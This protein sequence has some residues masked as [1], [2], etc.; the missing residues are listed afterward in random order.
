MQM[1]KDSRLHSA[2]CRSQDFS[3]MNI[4]ITL[5]TPISHPSKLDVPFSAMKGVILTELANH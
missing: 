5:E 3:L 1:A 4:I 2:Q